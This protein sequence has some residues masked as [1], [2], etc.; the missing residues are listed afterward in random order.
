MAVSVIKILKMVNI[1][2]NTRNILVVTDSLLEIS[3]HGILEKPMVIKPCQAVLIG[4]FL[5][6]TVL[7]L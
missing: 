6:L 3:M 7:Y 4:K 2:H 5:E 1:K